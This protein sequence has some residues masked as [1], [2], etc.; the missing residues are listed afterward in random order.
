MSNDL[1][2]RLSQRAHEHSDHCYGHRQ[3]M[4]GE[5]HLHDDICYGSYRICRQD[6]DKDLVVL[7]VRVRAIELLAEKH[8]DRYGDILKLLAGEPIGDTRKHGAD[9]DCTFCKDAYGT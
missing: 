2:K 3:L 7:M 4:C 1:V 8:P 5:H 6:E 9:C